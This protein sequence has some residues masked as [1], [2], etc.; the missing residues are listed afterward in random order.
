MKTLNEVNIEQVWNHFFQH[1]DTPS[2]NT[3]LEHY[4][5]QVKYTAE[6]LHSRFPKS[7]ELDDLYSVGIIG[8]VDAI[9][10]FDPA[11]NVK[12]ETYC[13]KRIYG[14]IIDDIRKRDR[15]P[16]LVRAR[17]QQLQKVTE[18]LESIFGR[19]PSD[20]E[21]ADELQ[22]NMEEFY[23]F[24]RDANASVLVSLNTKHSD[25]DAEEGFSQLDHI[26]N[27]KSQDPFIEIQRR[28]LKEYLIKG[29]SRQEQ[30]IFTLYHLE[31]MTMKEIGDSLGI[32]E[33][34]VSQLHTSIITRLKSHLK[35]R[36]CLLEC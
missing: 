28:D 8:L 2:R 30:L 36:S 23:N 20:E 35:E 14:A 17:A 9:N 34:R 7:V 32:S 16:R 24:Q 25:S 6:R 29:F 10:K 4:L 18:K 31:E 1:H 3:L 19:S 21:L 5:S 11:R 33:S 15:V 22:M 13:A 26:A 12:F 27:Q